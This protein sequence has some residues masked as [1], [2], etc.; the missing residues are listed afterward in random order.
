LVRFSPVARF[1][2]LLQNVWPG[3]G[4]HRVFFLGG[5]T[6]GASSW[7]LLSSAKFKNEWS[8]NSTFPYNFMDNTG[9]TLRLHVLLI[10]HF[11]VLPIIY[12]VCNLNTFRKKVKNVVTSKG[13][14]GGVSVNK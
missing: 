1:L 12:S 9:T 10:L 11:N 7:L 5:K 2:S 8:H 4:A 3:S 6:A 14:Q 13:I